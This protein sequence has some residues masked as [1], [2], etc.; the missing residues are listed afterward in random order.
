MTSRELE[1]INTIYQS[2]GRCSIRAISKKIRV[3]YDYGYLILKALLKEK[4]V[5]KQGNNVFILTSEGKSLI[6]QSERAKEQVFFKNQAMFSPSFS[7]EANF[8]KKDLK[9]QSIEHNFNKAEHIIETEDAE[10]IQ[11]SVN[12]LTFVKP[13]VAEKH[14]GN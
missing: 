9:G 12:R 10:Q 4:L 6:K 13:K 8:I 11:T 5:E 2:G 14:K 3:G 1:I 7:E